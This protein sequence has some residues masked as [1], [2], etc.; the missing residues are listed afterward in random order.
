MY[1]LVGDCGS[2]AKEKPTTTTTKTLLLVRLVSNAISNNRKDMTAVISNK[3]NLC[4]I[5]S[6]RKAAHTIQITLTLCL[7]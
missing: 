5:E 3:E 6:A 7:V 1:H 2:T 4:V